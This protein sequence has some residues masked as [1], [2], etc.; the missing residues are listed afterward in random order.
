MENYRDGSI[1]RMQPD[2]GSTGMEEGA[3]ELRN[4]GDL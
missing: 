1:R 3:Y 2:I 4:V